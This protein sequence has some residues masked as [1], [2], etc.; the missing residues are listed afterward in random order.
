MATD[1]LETLDIKQKFQIFSS[2]T[3]ISVTFAMFC[4]FLVRP[5][6]DLICI[7]R[8]HLAPPFI[9][10]HLCCRTVPPYCVSR[11]TAVSCSIEILIQNIL[12]EIS[13]NLPSQIICRCHTDDASCFFLLFLFFCRNFVFCLCFLFSTLGC[14]Y[15]CIRM[16]VGCM[17]VCIRKRLFYSS[18]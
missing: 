1:L 10:C 11:R 15:V 7:L 17:Y 13:L 6:C 12:W 5:S 14:M 4:R 3:Y 18:L 2:H 9:H 8:G 16:Y